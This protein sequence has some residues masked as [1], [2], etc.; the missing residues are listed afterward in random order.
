MPSLPAVIAALLATLVF[1]P[2][3]GEA[4]RFMV[5]N[6]RGECITSVS[7]LLPLAHRGTCR[8]PK[9]SAH[10]FNGKRSFS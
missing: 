10:P 8:V 9:Q 6:K 5:K 4:A 3:L 2:A 7:D 1:G